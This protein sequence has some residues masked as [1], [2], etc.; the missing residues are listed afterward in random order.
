M[1]RR[2]GTG[3]S[4]EGELPNVFAQL[5][6]LGNLSNQDEEELNPND[7]VGASQEPADFRGIVAPRQVGDVR[8][9]D[10]LA[11]LQKISQLPMAMS[12]DTAVRGDALENLQGMAGPKP[13]TPPSETQIMQG[14]GTLPAAIQ[15]ENLEG[16]SGQM[17][18]QQAAK[19]QE[20]IP[21]WLDWIHQKL[22]SPSRGLREKAERAATGQEE[23]NPA[24][25]DWLHQKLQAPSRGL[26]EKGQR[27]TERTAQIPAEGLPRNASGQ[28][29][30]PL[31]FLRQ[32]VAADPTLMEGLPEETRDLLA[33]TPANPE[34][35]FAPPA[36]AEAAPAPL[37]EAPQEA[38]A[39]PQ[40]PEAAVAPQIVPPDQPIS[41]A[42]IESYPEKKIE[43]GSVAKASG[44][45]QIMNDLTE[46]AGNPIPQE[47]LDRARQWEEVSSKRKELWNAE[48]K[49]LNRK[50]EAGE[51]T[52]FDKIALGIALAVP[53]LIALR[54]GAGAGLVAAGEGLK[55]F[56]G[57]IAGQQKK[58]SEEKSKTKERLQ[59][60]QKER[61]GQEEK[62][63]EFNKKI[64][65]SISDK[66]ARGFLKNKKPERIGDQIGIPTGDPEKILW[67]NAAKFDASDEGVKRAREVIKEADETIG[68]MR[69]SNKIVNRGLE[70]LDQLPQGTGV[71][72]AAKKNAQ[73][74]TSAGGGN[75]F[76]G[77]APQIDVVG[78]D[79]K[80]RKVDA[81]S[82]LK[83][84]FNVLQDLYNKQV[85]GGTRLTG[86]VVTHW[87][88]ILGDP[89]SI[90]DWFSQ[91]LNGFKDTLHSLKD[92]MNSREV[93][94]LTGKGFVRE[95]LESAFP[96][97][98]GDIL[99]SDQNIYNK[100]RSNHEEFRKK[101]K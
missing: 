16:L 47:Q 51:L 5:A 45:E 15:E 56:G 25:L 14:L 22:Q 39:A 85:L 42:Q 70:I 38:P 43:P 17:G 66:A 71:W 58:A 93:E 13:P 21:G 24:W 68:I 31:E 67:L 73:W 74:F 30:D 32:Q 63:I 53:I 91:D 78:P 99:E 18:A 54:Y 81:F 4:T 64:L 86:N 29:L 88:G 9:N 34:K 3:R 57:T 2:V 46:L 23:A 40:A 79:G 90:K 41:E 8:Q 12:E 52:T 33:N 59:E 60:I 95:P 27:E 26:I 97:Y 87:E 77:K 83:Q 82:Q 89:T 10:Y 92:V 69:D 80:T 48:E 62:D 49:E 100:M 20:E 76:G 55:S 98:Q 101:V 65:D 19:G 72:E 84:V 61:V 1:A 35:A 6:L 11:N 94:S 75:P 96:S 50:A 7:L 37:P 36:Q 28:L 44:D